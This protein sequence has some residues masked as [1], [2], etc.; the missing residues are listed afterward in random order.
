MLLQGCMQSETRGT[1]RVE[2][3]IAGVAAPIE[4]TLILSTSALDV[5]PPTD[6]DRAARFDLSRK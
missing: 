6:A 1:Y 4:G 2:I 3:E 5:P